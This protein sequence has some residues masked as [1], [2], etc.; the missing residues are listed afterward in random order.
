M[1][2]LCKIDHFLPSIW[3]HITV[4]KKISFWWYLLPVKNLCPTKEI[5][6]F[7]QSSNTESFL[8]DLI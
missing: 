2:K 5:M 6:F 3:L 7:S 4:C 8:F 1:M